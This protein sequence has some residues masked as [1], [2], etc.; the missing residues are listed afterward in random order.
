VVAI[1]EALLHPGRYS[2]TFDLRAFIPTLI[3]ALI[4]TPIQTSA[5]ELLLRGYLMQSLG[6]RIRNAFILSAISATIFMALH[7]GNP[8]MNSNAVLMALFYFSFG[9]FAAFV[10][11]K[12]GSLE[13]ALGMH[14]ANNLFSGLVANYAMS[15][16][17]TPSIFMVNELDAS[18]GLV[19]SLLA[20]LAFYLIIFKPWQ[21]TTE[22]IH[23]SDQ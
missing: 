5:E 2:V 18:F 10:T 14:A 3:A 15:A 7:F 4:F 19:S 23:E 21:K 9:F 8:E 17:P 20:M 16:L 1:V 13:L 22:V 12:D 11:L 6:L